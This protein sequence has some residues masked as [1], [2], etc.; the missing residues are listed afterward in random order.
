MATKP[1]NP[2]S[3]FGNLNLGNF[4]LSKFDF[5]KMLGD[6]KLPGADLETLMAGQRKNIEALTAANQTAVAGIQAVAKRQAEI[7]S[8]SMSAATTALQQLSG[9]TE[10]RERVAKQVDVTKEALEKA[11]ATMRELAETI[12]KSADEALGVI[13]KRVIESLDEVKALA[14]KK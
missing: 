7:L 10:P 5:T 4:D 9:I 1:T 3:P 11:L 2:F 13:N 6:F 14:A 12:T 8:E